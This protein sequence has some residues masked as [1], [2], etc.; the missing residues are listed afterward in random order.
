MPS[1]KDPSSL[2]RPTDGSPPAG[3]SSSTTGGGGISILYGPGPNWADG[4]TNPATPLPAEVSKIIFDLSSLT[5]GTAKIGGAALVG[6]HDTI[7]SGT[8]FSQLGLL[9]QAAHIEYAGGGNWADAT[10]NPATLVSSQL[11]KIISDLAGATGTAKIGGAALTGTSGTIAAGELFTQLGALKLAA[12]LEY[13]GGGNWADG[14]TNPATSIE[15]QLDKNIADLA[16]SGGAAKVGSAALVGANDTIAAGTLASQLILLKQAAHIE[17]AGGTNWADGTINPSTLVENQLDKIL[18][19]LGGSGGSAKIG[20]T[21]SGG[22]DPSEQSVRAQLDG[23]DTRKFD[24]DGGTITGTVRLDGGGTVSQYPILQNSVNET[25][26]FLNLYA[27]GGVL[28]LGS[29]FVANTPSIQ[30]VTTGSPITAWVELRLPAGATV[31]QVTVSWAGA[32][33]GSGALTAATYQ[34]VSLAGNGASPT[35][36]ITSPVSGVTTD[37]NGGT[38]LQMNTQVVTPTGGVFIANP[39]VRYF[40]II[41]SFAY[42]SGTTTSEVYRVQARFKPSALHP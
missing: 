20:A 15:A 17:Y 3:T 12:N 39:L 18:S 4:T 16:G 21:V 27:G 30:F 9:K 10:T 32:I 5:G 7:A 31:D 28:T 14:T 36:M 35:T 2:V 33:P 38:F 40:L 42:A 11:T 13:A 22:F 41:T 25:R 8:L 19:D 6:A 29:L 34:I 26:D 37:T 24:K 23:L 1:I